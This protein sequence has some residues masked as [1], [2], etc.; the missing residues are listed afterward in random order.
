MKSILLVDDETVIA[1][2]FQRTLRQ[3]KLNVKVAHTVEAAL[4]SVRKTRFDAILLEFNLRSEHCAHPRAGN[5]LRLVQQL[6]ILHFTVPVLM[7]TVMDGK[8]YEL[9]SLAAGADDFILKTTSIPSVLV[10]LR[11][12]IHRHR[13]VSINGW[14][15]A[16]LTVDAFT[17]TQH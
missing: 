16:R 17:P 7:F 11:A 9:S 15:R 3:C 4:R 8:P 5:G 6:R 12:L 13:Q 1:A 14:H 10:R 2:E